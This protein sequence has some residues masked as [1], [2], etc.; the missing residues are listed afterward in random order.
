MSVQHV[1]FLLLKLS[2]SRAGG[3]CKPV[4]GA[5]LCRAQ[6]GHLA[7]GSGEIPGRPVDA[8]LL[9]PEY[10]H[11][12]LHRELALTGACSQQ[13]SAAS[14]PDWLAVRM[15]ASDWSAPGVWASEGALCPAPHNLA[16][17]EGR[18]PIP[19]AAGP[20]RLLQP[21][22][23]QVYLGGHAATQSPLV[24]SSHVTSLTSY[25]WRCSSRRWSPSPPPRRCRLSRGPRPR[26][27]PLSGRS[28]DS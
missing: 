22:T 8:A 17:A 25:S 12:G 20:G 13:L 3:G 5:E 10:L 6:R 23:T 9:V 24:T 28:C 11:H 7:P 18:L 27:C 4:A 19:P 16:P 2:P 21:L 26:L 1:E 15:R 14:P